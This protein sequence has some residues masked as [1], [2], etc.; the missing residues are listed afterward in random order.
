[1]DLNLRGGQFGEQSDF[2]PQRKNL[3]LYFWCWKAF[4]QA[5]FQMSASTGA[6]DM[7]RRLAVAAAI[8]AGA[9][10]LGIGLYYL[11][12]KSDPNIEKKKQLEK[13]KTEAVG[14]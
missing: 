9:I 7:S 2:Q 8:A 11:T 1:M 3:R 5:L 6:S 14:C 4:V 12:K 13:L 10:G